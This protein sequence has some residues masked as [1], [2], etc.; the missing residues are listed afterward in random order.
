MV[1]FY[2]RGGSP[3]LM[4]DV[5]IAAAVAGMQSRG[6]PLYGANLDVALPSIFVFRAGDGLRVPAADVPTGSK[7][8]VKVSDDWKLAKPWVNDAGV[9]RE[10]KAATKSRGTWRTPSLD[11]ASFGGSASGTTTSGASPK[12]VYLP[13]GNE[14]TDLLVLAVTSRTNTNV[15]TTPAGWTLLTAQTIN[16]AVYSVYWKYAEATEPSVSLAYTGGSSG[17]F[18][19]QIAVFKKTDLTE[20][21]H[22]VG[23]PFVG[24]PSTDIGPISGITIADKS[25]VVV[26]GVRETYWTTDVPTLSGDGLTWSEIGQPTVIAGPGAGLVWGAASNNSGGPVTV[27]NKTFSPNGASSSRG[28]LMFEIK[29]FKGADTTIPFAGTLLAYFDPDDINNTGTGN[30]GY[31]DGS[32]PKITNKGSLGGLLEPEGTVSPTYTRCGGPNGNSGFAYTNG[33]YQ[34]SLLPASWAFLHDGTPYTMYY[35]YR[36]LA[37]NPNSL[38]FLV[39]TAVTPGSSSSRGLSLLYDDRSSVPREDQQLYFVSSGSTL[40]AAIT[41]ADEAVIP[42]F[43]HLATAVRSATGFAQYVDGKLVGSSAVTGAV[44]AL[45]PSSTLVVG[46]SG[47]GTSPHFGVGGILAIYSGDHTTVQRK[48]FANYVNARYGDLPSVSKG[49]SYVGVTTPAV[50]QL[51]SSSPKVI[52]LPPNTAAGDLMVMTMSLRAPSTMPDTPAGWTLFAS[53]T[54]SLGTLAMYWKLAAVGEANPTVTFA[55]SAADTFI[56]QVAVWRGADLFNPIKQVGIDTS[57]TSSPNIGPILGISVAAGNMVSVI[58]WQARNWTTSDVLTGDGLQWD[59]VSDSS[60]TLGGDAGIRWDASINTT[61]E[62][63]AVTSKTF[64]TDGTGNVGMGFM[65]EIRAG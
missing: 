30:A 26:L 47:G 40:N 28:G 18:V 52:T 35:V 11:A 16:A 44:S 53:T 4:K 7:I 41:S 31:V 19:A 57:N 32:S 17:A 12:V 21:V 29:G 59:K 62:E 15:F 36:S 65:F 55:A 64:I 42:P 54:N 2:G 39:G 24:G 43:W 20:G 49:L 5:G 14:E 61:G 10:T 38:H 50:M 48:Q 33:R 25:A 34:S 45:D 9:W 56:G 60:T 22:Q 46:S 27:A 8:W 63:V 13:T 23:T 58:G 1:D 51:G 37:T 3:F 6:S